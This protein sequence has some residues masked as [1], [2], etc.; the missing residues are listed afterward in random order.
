MCFMFPLRVGG[1]DRKID[2]KTMMNPV[3]QL[4]QV[5][6]NVL[7]TNINYDFDNCSAR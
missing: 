5:I 1:N 2:T 3:D 7:L 4:F 6:H